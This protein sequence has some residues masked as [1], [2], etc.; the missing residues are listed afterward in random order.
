MRFFQEKFQILEVRGVRKSFR[1]IN[2]E[3]LNAPYILLS[4]LVKIQ[5]RP[6][7]LE[8]RLQTHPEYIELWLNIKLLW[9]CIFKLILEMHL[10]TVLELKSRQNP[11]PSSFLKKVKTLSKK[12]PSTKSKIKQQSSKDLQ[13]T[14]S[15]S[16][17]S[18][19]TKVNSKFVSFWCFDKKKIFFMEMSRK[20]WFMYE[21]CR[22]CMNGGL[23]I[24]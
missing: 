20:W 13:S 16:E 11:S 1:K 10:G 12:I 17:T 24:L 4:H 22:N 21:M 8:M 9:R 18:S 7:F 23:Y 3:F 19:N 2:R 5:K 14:S 15:T 6:Q